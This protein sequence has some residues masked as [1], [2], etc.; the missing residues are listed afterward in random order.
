MSYYSTNGMGRLLV[1]CSLEAHSIAFHIH[2]PTPDCHGAVT[3][4]IASKIE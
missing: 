2:K 1:S 3:S 4:E